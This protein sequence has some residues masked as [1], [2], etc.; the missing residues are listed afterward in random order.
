[1]NFQFNVELTEEEYL[2]YNRFIMFKSPYNANR[3]SKIFDIVL[4]VVLI[5]GALAFI[6]NL[7]LGEVDVTMI[8][9]LVIIALCKFGYKP[10]LS[11]LLSYQIKSLKKKGKLPYS[12]SAT[13]EFYE[14]RITEVT[15]SIRTE[16][17]YSSVEKISILSGKFVY[18]HINSSMA[19]ILPMRSFESEAQ[20][21]SF[22]EF[23]EAKT[24]KADVYADA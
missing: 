16:V 17:L 9:C 7:L 13:V 2:D 5:L 3:T 8:V 14:D 12:S 6:L 11:F 22:V 15:D 19:Y 23:I 4:V 1:M 24:V 20:Y 10:L 18:I 21:T